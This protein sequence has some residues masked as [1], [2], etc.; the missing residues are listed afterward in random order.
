LYLIRNILRSIS[1]YVPFL[2]AGVASLLKTRAA[3]QLENVA[4]RHQFAVLQRSTKKRPRV[5][6]AEGLCGFGCPAYEGISAAA[7][8]IP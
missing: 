4:L 7:D 2:L 3:L 6:A 8:S 5:Q 1:G